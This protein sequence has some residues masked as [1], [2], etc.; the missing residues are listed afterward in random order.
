MS[1]ESNGRQDPRREPC[2]EADRS[3]EQAKREV[4]RQK[5]ALLDE[6]SRRMEQQ[7]SE[8]GLFSMRWQLT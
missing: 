6:I 2:D 7:T 4:D 3:Y 1:V 8:E 5:D